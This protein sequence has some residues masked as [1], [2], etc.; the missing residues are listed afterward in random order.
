MPPPLDGSHYSLMCNSLQVLVEAVGDIERCTRLCLEPLAPEH[1]DKLVRQLNRVWA[2]VGICRHPYCLLYCETSKIKDYRD[3]IFFIQSVLYN[4]RLLKRE[5]FDTPTV[6]YTI[7]GTHW[8][9][10]F[11]INQLAPD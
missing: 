5:A 10:M 2:A 8:Y 1:L 11:F 4:A 6:C 9:H 7:K 3:C